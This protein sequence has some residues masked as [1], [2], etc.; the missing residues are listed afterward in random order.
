M[1]LSSVKTG[2]M[3]QSTL[4]S[5]RLT[6][7]FAASHALF[8]FLFFSGDLFAKG[9]ILIA[10]PSC[11][12]TKLSRAQVK[13]YYFKKNRQWPD[14]ST[15]RFFDRHESNPARDI[16]LQTILNRTARQ[17]DNFWIEQKFKSGD[18]AP[19]TVDEDKILIDLISRF[20]GAISYLSEDVSVTKNVKV[21]QVTDQ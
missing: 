6:M 10:H 21:I 16:F 15:V 4:P 14:Q 1:G 20:P 3:I 18:S 9:I 2:I 5:A 12:L 17:V 7:F 11:P 19:S 13:D 8:F